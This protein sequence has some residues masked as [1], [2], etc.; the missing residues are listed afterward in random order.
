MKIRSYPSRRTSGYTIHM[1]I[2]GSRERISRTIVVGSLGTF[3]VFSGFYR[4]LNCIPPIF[5]F[6][7]LSLFISFHIPIRS[8]ISCHLSPQPCLGKIVGLAHHRCIII[9]IRG[10]GG[11]EKRG[12]YAPPWSLS[13]DKNC[14]GKNESGMS[15]QHSLGQ[16]SAYY[17]QSDSW[18]SP[19][20]GSTALNGSTNMDTMPQGSFQIIHSPY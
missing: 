5:S 10:G 11:E 14:V 17:A 3:W 7:P 12:Q 16:G 6:F 8:F 19:G 2:L 4:F 13:V 20:G 1:S 9:A 18:R 15:D